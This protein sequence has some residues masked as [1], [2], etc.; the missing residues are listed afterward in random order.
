MDSLFSQS[1]GDED[2]GEHRRGAEGVSPS[3]APWRTTVSPAPPKPLSFA[4]LGY[5][6]SRQGG[7]YSPKGFMALSVIYWVPV[8]WPERI[9]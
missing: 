9:K 3:A 7:D 5:F 8:D 2:S 4:Y 6:S 1:C